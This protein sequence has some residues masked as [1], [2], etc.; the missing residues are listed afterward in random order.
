MAKTNLKR[1]EQTNEIKKFIESEMCVDN[2]FKNTRR[3]EYVDARRI[4]FYIL[5]NKFLLT[6]H[7]IGNISNRNH[8]TIIHAQKD[9]NFII[10]GD[11]VL[12]AVYKKTLQK[13]EFILYKPLLTKREV[14]IKKIEELNQE[15]LKI[16]ELLA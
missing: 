8:A 3:R 14:L 10:K 6:Y 5:R 12:E 15:L 13:A 7:E 11:V 9:F 1:L 4:F 16:P 2:I